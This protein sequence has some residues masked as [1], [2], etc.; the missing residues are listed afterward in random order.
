MK[1]INYGIDA[2]KV[3][4]NLLLIGIFLLL[5]SFFLSDDTFP[6]ISIFLHRSSFIP[7]ICLTITGLLMIAYAKFGKFK[8]RDR[9]LN[10]QNWNGNEQVLDVGTGL[11]L[12]MI[13][14]AKKL[15]TGK[16]YGIDIFNTYDLSDNSIE[17]TKI[18]AALE[19]VT[20]KVEIL[21]ENILKTNFGSNYFDV[22]VSNLC[23]HNLYKKE[24][25]KLAC[26][27]I[28]RI[29]KQNGKVIISD[30]QKTGEYRATFQE[31][32]MTVEKIGTY[33]FD[34]FPPL[35][36]IMATKK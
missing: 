21:K 27:E 10:L 7:G 29:L 32:G 8:H 25:R 30:F 3:I 12:L 15:T 2:P 24:E 11:G 9:I 5:C 31:L 34:T 26:T 18:N 4:R 36:I 13:G 35:T 16:S 28:H 1:K 33:Y 23:L 14:A 6:P 19:N 17:Q 22:I 20:Q